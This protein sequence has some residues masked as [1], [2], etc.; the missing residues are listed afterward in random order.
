VSVEIQAAT[1][2]SGTRFFILMTQSRKVINTS[3]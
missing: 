3:L 1:M 2:A